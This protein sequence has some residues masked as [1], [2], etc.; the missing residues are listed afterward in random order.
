MPLRASNEFSEAIHS[1]NNAVKNRVQWPWLRRCSD[2]GINYTND[3]PQAVQHRAIFHYKVFARDSQIFGL[4]RAPQVEYPV[5]PFGYK[6][7]M[8]QVGDSLKYLNTEFCC[9]DYLRL[10]WLVPLLCAPLLP[11]HGRGRILGIFLGLEEGHAGRF[12][13]IAHYSE[14]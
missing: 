3:R 1:G 11:G 12:P 6:G 14:I 7:H 2:S 5:F 13:Q 9:I 10:R 8:E 4:H